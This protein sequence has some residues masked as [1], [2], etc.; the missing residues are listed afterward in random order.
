[1]ALLPKLKTADGAVLDFPKLK[2]GA[3]AEVVGPP[4]VGA[5]WLLSNEVVVVEVVVAVPPKENKPVP[6]TKVGPALLATVAVPKL[7]AV[8]L[9]AT[10]VWPKLNGFTAA[11]AVEPKAGG[12]ADVAGGKD[13]N[14][15]D[16]AGAALVLVAGGE[17]AGGGAAWD[18][19]VELLLAWKVKSFE[20]VENPTVLSALVVAVGPK[21]KEGFGNAWTVV[22]STAVDEVDGAPKVKVDVSDTTGFTASVLVTVEAVTD[23]VLEVSGAPKLKVRLGDATEGFAG[24]AGIPRGVDLTTAGVGTVAVDDTVTVDSEGSLNVTNVSGFLGREAEFS[25]KATEE[26]DEEEVVPVP[27]SFEEE[28]EKGNPPIDDGVGTRPSVFSPMVKAKPPAAGFLADS[29]LFEAASASFSFMMVTS[30]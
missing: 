27:N 12:G 2:V 28:S 14:V 20:G 3:V 19:G 21:L 26:E 5:A 8:V 1:M 30:L 6:A 23:W 22:A 25:V 4:K 11:V 7:L 15:R 10:V 17:Y 9:L 18:A 24:S 16:A 13:P 29:S